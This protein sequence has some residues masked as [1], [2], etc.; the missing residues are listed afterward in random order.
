MVENIR[1]MA[2]FL[3]YNLTREQE[4]K[5]AGFFDFS[6]Y[7]DHCQLGN[8]AGWNEGEGHFVRK[9]KVGDWKNY[10]QLDM[11]EEWG[12]WAGEEIEALEIDHRIVYL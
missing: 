12:A 8:K 1:N 6:N 10:M 11:V 4:E 2:T 3:G 9:G 7:K 5:V